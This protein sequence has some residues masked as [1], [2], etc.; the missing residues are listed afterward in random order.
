MCICWASQLVL[1]VKNLPANAGDI[2]D[3]CLI[4]GSG[5][6]PGGAHSNSLQYSCLENPMDRGAWQATAHRVSKSQTKL[7][8]FSTHTCSIYLLIPSPNLSCPSPVVTISLFSMFVSL[9]LFWNKFICIFLSESTYKQY[10]IFVFFCL[11]Y[12]TQYDNL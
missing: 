9:C 3:V 11:T 6:S 2:T 4:P 8:W 5:R 10:Y 7:K 12:F 1:V